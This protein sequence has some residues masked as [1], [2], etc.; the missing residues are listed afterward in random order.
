MEKSIFNHKNVNINTNYFRNSVND[1]KKEIDFDS[2]YYKVD[3]N[4]IKFMI[5]D[6]NK[7]MV[8][9]SNNKE[10]KKSQVEI[11]IE[12]SKLRNKINISEDPNYVLNYFKTIFI[13]IN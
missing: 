2:E 8:I 11:I 5:Y 3:I 7:E 13:N 12:N 6:F 1:N 4:K 9:N 10:E